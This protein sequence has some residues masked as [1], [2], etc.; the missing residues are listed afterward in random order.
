MR[1]ASIRLYI[2]LHTVTRLYTAAAGCLM[3]QRAVHVA[4]A[5]VESI[6]DM[7]I[8]ICIHF[9]PKSYDLIYHLRSHL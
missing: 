6:C 9:A 2:W 7:H 5:R 3:L 8:F 4:H 1:S